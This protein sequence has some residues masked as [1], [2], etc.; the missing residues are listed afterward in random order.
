MALM[1]KRTDEAKVHLRIDDIPVSL[2]DSMQVKF[3]YSTYLSVMALLAAI[4]SSVFWAIHFKTLR[5]AIKLNIPETKYTLF[6][7]T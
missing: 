4:V 1:M 3:G 6:C 2:E 7:R 5:G